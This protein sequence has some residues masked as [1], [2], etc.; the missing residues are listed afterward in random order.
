VGRGG[1]IKESG[2]DGSGGTRRRRG[3]EAGGRGGADEA[4]SPE[5]RNGRR[6]TARAAV[7]AKEA[8]GGAEGTSYV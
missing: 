7:D 5:P 6:R 2:R 8:E 3:R 4:G 1:L